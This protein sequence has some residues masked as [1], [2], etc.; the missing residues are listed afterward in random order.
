MA[1]H[2]SDYEHDHAALPQHP[3]ADIGNGGRLIVL[4][5]ILTS[6][7]QGMF[8]VISSPIGHVWSSDYKT[9]ANYWTPDAAKV[10]LPP[11]NPG[12]AQ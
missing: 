12:S 2:D 3:S 1:E 11:F 7:M 4:L 10:E 5:A 8:V 9:S 6:I